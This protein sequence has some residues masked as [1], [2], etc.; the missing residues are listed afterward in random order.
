MSILKQSCKLHAICTRAAAPSQS[1]Y[2]SGLN[3]APATPRQTAKSS[4]R[5]PNL[6]HSSCFTRALAL[7]R[8][9]LCLALSSRVE[10]D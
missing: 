10:S 5:L 8:P 9:V 2:Q 6:P 7:L 4:V 3:R 1:E